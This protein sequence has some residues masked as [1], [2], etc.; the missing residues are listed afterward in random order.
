MN[1]DQIPDAAI[2]DV[3][4]ADRE[5]FG[6]AL[7][8]KGV[9]DAWLDTEQYMDIA[10]QPVPDNQE[11]FVEPLADGDFRRKPV[12]LFVDLQ[13]ALPGSLDEKVRAHVED[14]LERNGHPAA[15]D[16]AAQVAVSPAA[17]PGALVEHDAQAAMASAQAALGGT[18]LLTIVVISVPRARSD[19]VLSAVTHSDREIQE[20]DVLAIASSLQVLDWE[21]FRSEASEEV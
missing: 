8:L 4:M 5:L 11:L 19:I 10:H 21:L 6:G 17:R 12:I 2:I 15:S 9:P 7:R 3:T 16:R 14:L 1:E 18:E 13:E 20:L